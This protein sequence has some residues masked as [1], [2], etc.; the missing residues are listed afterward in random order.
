MSIDKVKKIVLKYFGI[1]LS[2]D[3]IYGYDWDKSIDNGFC[4]GGYYYVPAAD[5]ESYTGFSIV[6]QAED[7]GDGTLWI[8]FTTYS[9]DLDIYWDSDESI[10]KK[11]YQMTA[12][13]AMNSKDLE[14]GYQGMA[15]V[16]KDGESYKLKYYK[17]Y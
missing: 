15:I 12:N 4:K 9:L 6:E 2:D 17:Q 8:Y 16:K 11:Y 3:E 1:K 5:G 7:A 10:P 13:E 14:S